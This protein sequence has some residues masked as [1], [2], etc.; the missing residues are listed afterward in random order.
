MSYLREKIFNDSI[1]DVICDDMVFDQF[2]IFYQA[3][4]Y[5]S[6]S[7]DYTTGSMIVYR[8]GVATPGD[9]GKAFSK[10]NARNQSTPG[11][12]YGSTDVLKNPSLSFRLTP[13]YE[14]VNHS[15][16]STQLIDESERFYDTCLPDLRSCF[17]ANGAD[18][19]TNFD[20]NGEF[21]YHS[22]SIPTGSIVP[23]GS[24]SSE[25][26]SY[27]MF[28]AP[29]S[30]GANQDPRVDNYWTWSYPYESR[31]KPNQRKLS[32]NDPNFG[33]YSSNAVA[34][35]TNR[36]INSTDNPPTY[37][38]MG[39][40]SR[41]I[42]G[43]IPIC[44]GDLSSNAVMTTN[45]KNSLTVSGSSWLFAVD[46]DLSNL[47]WYYEGS[48]HQTP[49]TSSMRSFSD[50]AKFYFGFGELNNVT[51]SKSS[52]TKF[53]GNNYPTFK[54][55]S[56]DIA[57]SG[58]WKSFVFGI[59]PVIR[60]WKRGLYS[61]LPHHSKAHFRR[62]HYGQFRDMLEQRPFSKSIN[63][64]LPPFAF[65]PKV[66]PSYSYF[67]VGTDGKSKKIG[68]I[69]AGP[70]LISFVS[71]SYSV[72]AKG[73]GSIFNNFIDPATKGWYQNL[74]SEAT[75]SLPYFDGFSLENV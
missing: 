65:E 22:G 53:G 66:V 37:T 11:S 73:I 43:I 15:Y 48:W 3:S 17:K 28:N 18:V 68:D 50:S 25:N 16:R 60:G 44:P 56:I 74:S 34:I 19:W 72:D 59:G 38:G 30:F 45:S 32:T 8:N 27:I 20:E 70:V 5:G 4:F 14:R 47:N 71:Q 51:I 13:W 1:T 7:D 35:N 41:P 52:E 31:Y 69:N 42:D 24:T 9:R 62:D 55:T 58:R 29:P 64:S 57:P 26:L 49:I 46:C 36:S 63:D 40:Y 21:C 75:S 67:S 23:P 61:A 54:S 33:I 12:V 6:M 2:D 39:A 10:L